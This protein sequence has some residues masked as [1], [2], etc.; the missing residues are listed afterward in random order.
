MSKVNITK[1]EYSSYTPELL[2]PY[3]AVANAIVNQ[4]DFAPTERELVALAVAAVHDLPYVLYAHTR[5]ALHTG[6]TD[7]Q[8]ALASKG[9]KPGGLTDEETVVYTTAL[10]LAE[11]KTPL[12]EETWQRAEASLGKVRCARLAHVVGLYLY[13]G[14]LLKMGAVSAPTG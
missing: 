1:G 9:N 8:I 6:M 5:I 7:Q 14:S 3:A 10:E 4:K 12:K 11:T 2:Q 13:T